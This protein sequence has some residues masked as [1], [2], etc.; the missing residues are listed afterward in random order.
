MFWEEILII[1]LLLLPPVILWRCKKFCE[2][3]PSTVVFR[4][5]PLGCLTMWLLTLLCAM[6]MLWIFK[7]LRTDPPEWLFGV[8]YLVVIPPGIAVIVLLARRLNRGRAVRPHGCL[9]PIVFVS[10]LFVGC[11]I[12]FS[13]YR[14]HL[15]DIDHFDKEKNAWRVVYLPQLQDCRVAFEQRHAHPFLAEYDYRIR[16]CHGKEEA[17]FQ[18]WA[19]TG[20]RTFVNVYQVADDMLLLREKDASYLVDMTQ[21]QVYLAKSDNRMT[22]SPE[23][24][25]LFTVPLSD[26]AVASMGVRSIDGAPPEF[27]VDFEGGKTVL[28]VPCDVDL[29]HC[30]YIGCIMDDAFYTADEQPEGEGHPRYRQE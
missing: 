5:V 2:R 4:A 19:N 26:K 16:L 27:Y 1:F 12:V 9:Y 23:T 15:H 13:G 14:R 30:K 21:G 25:I 20:G 8:W 11:C 22:V 29:S 24:K 28:G 6:A 3:H 7:A 10:F 17:Y 18:L